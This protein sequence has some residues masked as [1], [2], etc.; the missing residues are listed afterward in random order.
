[1]LKRGQQLRVGKSGD[2]LQIERKVTSERAKINIKKE[3]K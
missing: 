1:M 2:L 3:E